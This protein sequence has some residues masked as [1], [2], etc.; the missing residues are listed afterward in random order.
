MAAEVFSDRGVFAVGPVRMLFAVG[1]FN[2]RRWD[3]A[4]DGERFL[5]VT[6]YTDNEIVPMTLVVN[7][8]AALKE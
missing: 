3:I 2:R 6:E 8:M 7:W 5:F 1:S 4:P